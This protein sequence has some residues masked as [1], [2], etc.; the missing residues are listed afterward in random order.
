MVVALTLI[1]GDS[2]WQSAQ[3][4]LSTQGINDPQDIFKSQGRLSSFK[5]NDEAHANSCC[6]SQLW[7]R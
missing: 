6:Q 4:D 2:G 5:I 7:L 3:V 1:F